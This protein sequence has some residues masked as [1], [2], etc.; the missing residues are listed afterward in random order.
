[1]KT[2]ST[3]FFNIPELLI[4]VA[5]LL[6]RRGVS[7]LLQTC[8]QAQT[9]LEPIL[10]RTLDF[11]PHTSPCSSARRLLSTG[12]QLYAIKRNIHHVR[13]IRTESLSTAFLFNCFLSHALRNDTRPST[14]PAWLPPLDKSQYSIVSLPLPTNL[15]HLQGEN[16]SPM[17]QPSEQMFF[18]TMRSAQDPH[19]RLLQ[20]CWI[21]SQCTLLT[22]LQLTLELRTRDDVHCLT[23]TLTEVTALKT[24]KLVIVDC[25][26]TWRTLFS[27]IVLHCPLGIEELSVSFKVPWSTT[28]ANVDTEVSEVVLA[29]TPQSSTQDLDQDPLLPLLRLR[30]ITVFPGVRDNHITFAAASKVFSRCPGLVELIFHNTGCQQGDAVSI[31]TLLRNHCPRF[32]KL[33]HFAG[34]Y[35]KDR[36]L[37]LAIMDNLAPQTFETIDLSFLD[38]S[39]TNILRLFIGR[40]S[41]TLREIRMHDCRIID[42]GTIQCILRDCAQLEELRLVSGGDCQIEVTLA[43]AVAFKWASRK[44]KR[45]ELSVVFSGLTETA[46]YDTYDH[47]S[48]GH[49]IYDDNDTFIVPYY[50]RQGPLVL[51]DAVQPLFTMLERFYRQLGELTELE[52]LDLGA[53]PSPLTPA[54]LREKGVFLGSFPG[55]LS[56]GNESMGRPGYLRLLEGW[57]KLKYLRGSVQVF[58]VETSGT[59]G[60]DEFAWMVDNWPCLRYAA[61]LLPRS[62]PWSRDKEHLPEIQWLRDRKPQLSLH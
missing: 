17:K 47:V 60:Q 33:R 4:E 29:A 18:P 3:R 31:A 15:T 52:H 57:K 62:G 50:Q 5:S 49:G 41:M 48:Y 16:V 44:I 56:L 6:D 10:I 39:A 61:F 42:S 54:S 11:L 58:T 35:G 36:Q 32:R 14:I 45:L 7:R 19:A 30:K 27:V 53:A 55:M 8:H 23:R 22:S 28:R 40:H 46:I 12:T 2:A 38:T 13:V 25:P 34:Y 37:A 26:T 43:D 51:T 24:F 21:I 59:V 20:L 9:V 1:M